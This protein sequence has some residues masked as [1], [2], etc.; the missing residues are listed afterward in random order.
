MDVLND[1]LNERK[2]HQRLAAT[3]VDLYL[4]KFF[5][6]RVEVP[7]QCRQSNGDG[8]F[9]FALV[10]LEAIDAIKVALFCDDQRE[11]QGRFGQIRVY[12]AHDA[13]LDMHA[14]S[15]EQACPHPVQ[16]PHASEHVQQA[17]Q[18]Q[19]SFLAALVSRPADR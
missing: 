16:P 19:A 17:F 15:C 11:D 7:L 13:G 8:H 2:I 1:L 10:F 3:E 4:I 14:F 5:R 18:A 12:S 9:P 6:Q